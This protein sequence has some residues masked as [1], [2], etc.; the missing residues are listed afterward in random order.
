M[1]QPVG[2]KEPGEL[3]LR[4][5]QGDRRVRLPGASI[6]VDGTA[7]ESR[8]DRVPRIGRSTCLPWLS[9]QGRLSS[10]RC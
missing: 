1:G 9:G 7:R 6:A 2:L 5:L 10:A 3:V 4:L 8:S